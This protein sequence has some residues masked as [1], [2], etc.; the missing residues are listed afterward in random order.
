MIYQDK[1]ITQ[2]FYGLEKRH[3]INKPMIKLSVVRKYISK[4]MKYMKLK[5]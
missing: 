5:G 1:R 2:Y 4:D 3:Y